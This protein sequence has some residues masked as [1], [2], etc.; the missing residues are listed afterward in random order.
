MDPVTIAILVGLAVAA[1]LV[2]K[3]VMKTT[4]I[5]MKAAVFL[6]ILLVLYGV[7]V[8]RGVIPSLF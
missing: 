3:F 4:K 5:V 2:Y 6:V 1:F 8:S 7:L